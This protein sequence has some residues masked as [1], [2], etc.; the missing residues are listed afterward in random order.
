M[1]SFKDID[2]KRKLIMKHYNKPLFYKE[3]NEKA[4]IDS[5]SNQCV[6]QFHL[7]WKFK[8]QKL[9]EVFWYGKGCAIFKASIDIF[10]ELSLNKTKHEILN[11]ATEYEKMINQKSFNEKMMG[12]L[13]IFQN[14]KKQLNRLNCANMISQA[15]IK[16][17]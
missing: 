6:D 4:N 15:I 8:N 17:I 12:K 16:H 7:K 1:T 5:Y 10:L 13:I 14:V 3:F 2:I 11:L 9:I